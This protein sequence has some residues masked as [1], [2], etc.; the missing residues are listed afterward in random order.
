MQYNVCKESEFIM[1][2]IVY[3]SVALMLSF[4]LMAQSIQLTPFKDNTLYETFNGATSNGAGDRLFIGKT[5]P[6]GNNAL[7]RAVLK[8]DLS[9]VPS[10]AIIQSVS[11]QVHIINEPFDATPFT[12]SLHALQADWGEGTSNGGG[13]GA[14][15]SLGDA[16]WQHTFYDNVAW[17]EEGGEYNSLASSTAGFDGF[18]AGKNVLFDSTADMVTEVQMWMA[19]P[20]QNFGWIILGDETTSGN[21]RGLSSREGVSPPVLT[22]NFTIPYLIFRNG[23]E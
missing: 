17:F 10:D 1:K 7:R 20:N 4:D 18:D 23:F 11:L 13:T 8:F 16:T 9:Q 22:V 14:P 12:A 21:A 15:S 6:S 3:L 19:F 2:L 5:G